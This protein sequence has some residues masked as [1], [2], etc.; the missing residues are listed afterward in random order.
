MWETSSGSFLIHAGTRRTCERR[1]VLC[2]CPVRI[3][4]SW[5]MQSDPCGTTELGSRG[6]PGA[7]S[8]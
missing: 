2:V 8:F 4:H 1:Q 6:S 5:T 7:I 3:R